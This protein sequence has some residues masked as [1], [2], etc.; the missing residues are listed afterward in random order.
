MFISTVEFGFL[1]KESK[2][3]DSNLVWPFK[4]LQVLWLGFIFWT[5]KVWTWIKP[6]DCK[7][8]SLILV[9]KQRD[10]VCLCVETLGKDV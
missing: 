5:P 10:S 3:T 2:G 8:Q 4:E 9:D 1:T 6:S 7:E